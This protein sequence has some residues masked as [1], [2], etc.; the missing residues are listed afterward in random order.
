ML[1]SNFIGARKGITALDLHDFS[2]SVACYLAGLVLHMLIVHVYMYIKS[3]VIMASGRGVYGNCKILWLVPR[4]YADDDDDDDDGPR[5]H[6]SPF[7]LRVSDSHQFGCN[8]TG[9]L[10]R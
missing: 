7:T 5:I 9:G 10:R 6:G 2:S 4:S 1:S 8:A 3:R